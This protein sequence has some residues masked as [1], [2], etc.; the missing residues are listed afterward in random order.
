VSLA[1]V[2][3]PDP[4]PPPEALGLIAAG[5]R[6][7]MLVA[8]GMKDAGHAVHAV[9]L[10]GQYDPAIARLCDRFIDVGV[11]RLG[12]WG[13]ALRRMNVR[14]AVMVGRVDK[15]RLHLWR[16]IV[17]NLPDLRT[18]RMYARLRADKRSHS[19]LGAIADE[20]A[21]DGVLL[22]DSTAHISEHLAQP[23]V[24]TDRQPTAA[25][26]ADIALGWPI[27]KD[28][29]RLDIGQSIA[30]RDR[31]VIAVEA[32]EGTD[33]MIER[34]GA[35]CAGRPWTLLKGARAGHDRRAD[36]PT[37]GPDTVR[38]MHRC[39]GRCLAVAA[40]DVIIIDKAQTVRLADELGIAVVGIAAV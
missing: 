22:I 32:V 39:G 27:L 6:L 9:G 13:R 15:S 37:I 7:P 3:L 35:L 14:Y 26:R 28:M 8:Q 36:V 24:M 23:G 12:S 40:G 2:I 33:R 1:P 10:R 38:T 20:L 29:L 16:D 21:R 4:P 18:A 19:I 25:Q 17:A 30:I 11:L 5:G 34:A 31:D